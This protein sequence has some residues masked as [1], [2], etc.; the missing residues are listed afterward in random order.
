M[1]VDGGASPNW[2]EITPDSTGS[3]INGT[4]KQLAPMHQ[5]RLDFA[6]G[7]LPNGDVIVLGGEYA[8]DGNALNQNNGN[9]EYSDSGEIYDPTTN[10]WTTIASDPH[11]SKNVL[12]T[13]LG[14]TNPVNITAIGDA[15]SEVLPDGDIL[16]GN[17]FDNGTE[18]YI[19]QFNANG[20]IGAG[21]WITGPNKHFSNEASGEESWVKL[22]N[23]DI[24]TYDIYAS[25]TANRGEGELYIPSATGGIG[26]WIA[27]TN[28]KITVLTGAAFGY[29]LGGAV[30]DPEGTVLF[31][32][33]NGTTA[34]YNTTTN[35][36]SQGPLMPKA[37]VTGSTNPVQLG[38]G[39]A[40][41]AILPNGDALLAMSPLGLGAT[42]PAPTFLYEYNPTLNVFTNV[43][44][45]ASV[46]NQSLL[47]SF[48]DAM[49]VLPTTSGLPQLL[50]TSGGV[51]LAFY[52]LAPGD[53]ANP[54][55]APTITSF[56]ENANGSFTLTGTQLNGL[57]E[58]AAY[59][60]DKQM[61]ENYP[62]VQLIDLFT[63]T[64]YYATTSNWS[65]SGVATGNTPE[66]VNVALPPG[67]GSN[68]SVPFLVFAIV[69]G[70]P[71][72]PIVQW[73][74]GP[75]P[76]SNANGALANPS[77]VSQ[78][79]GANAPAVPGADSNS[80][81]AVTTQALECHQRD[82]STGVQGR[83]QSRIR[84]G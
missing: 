5:A 56:T 59:G 19:P 46:L 73:F 79:A 14:Y 39:D 64:V 51:N 43:T 69:D 34:L 78:V 31:T 74:A 20:T 9:T 65:S 22:P 76:I 27:A 10:V 12:L 18:I 72:V 82:N 80:P 40:P 66:T 45:P 67:I 84:L 26:K 63:G 17:I 15:P 28:G 55:W 50:L 6:S 42:Y 25:L 58:G 8:S 13:N 49:L 68:G 2:Y 57:D 33:A 38:M 70:I 53:G 23:G 41:A 3:Y 32:G 37:S 48:N 35:T 1:I 29:E 62:L 44:P 21:S 47:N 24:L 16:V 75:G 52:T 11:T 71:S 4:W 83:T 61:A 7:V 81:P 30:L 54:S 36:W 77:V 60:D